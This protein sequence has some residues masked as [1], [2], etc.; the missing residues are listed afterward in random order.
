M[1]LDGETGTINDYTMRM[2]LL[3][4]LIFQPGLGVPLEVHKRLRGVGGGLA[5]SKVKCN[6]SVT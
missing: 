6:N 1:F 5:E 4:S 3:L 2:W